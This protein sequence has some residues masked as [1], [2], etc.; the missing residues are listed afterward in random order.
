MLCTSTLT[1]RVLSRYF[2]AITID[3]SGG[4]TAKRVRKPTIINSEHTTSI[5]II[6]INVVSEPMPSTEGKVP[7]SH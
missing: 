6:M 2:S 3:T 1:G 4:I 5:T 7:P